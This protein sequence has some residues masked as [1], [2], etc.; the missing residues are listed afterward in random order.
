MA[1]ITIILNRRRP[2][3]AQIPLGYKIQFRGQ[4]AIARPIV[5]TGFSPKLKLVGGRL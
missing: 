4:Q 3:V 1:N 5:M 2:L